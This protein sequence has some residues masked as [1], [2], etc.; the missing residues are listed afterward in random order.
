M[1]AVEG[2]L[3]L[4][5]HNLH[6]LLLLLE[7]PLHLREHLGHVDN[8]ALYICFLL[9]KVRLFRGELL[10]LRFRGELL[11]LLLWFRGELLLLLL[12]FR[13]GLLLLLLLFQSG[14]LLLLLVFPGGLSRLL[15]FPG[16]LS[17]HGPPRH[18][19]QRRA[20]RRA[21]RREGCPPGGHPGGFWRARAN[22][23]KIVVA[24]PR[25][26]WWSGAKEAAMISCKAQ[27][28]P[29]AKMAT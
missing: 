15:V 13:G 6:L 10:L 29:A 20:R 19:V 28:L 23:A 9:I 25:H 7:Q 22:A 14:L 27:L 24:S 4:L 3:L 8:G 21:P 17:L 26:Q 12:L 1:L 18:T 2:L 11:L 5:E 16:V